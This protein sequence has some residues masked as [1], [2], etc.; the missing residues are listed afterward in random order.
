MRDRRKKLP[1]GI[2]NFETIIKEDYYYVDKTGLIADLIE[3][4]G[5]VTLFTRPRRF[6]KSLNMSMLSHFFSPNTDKSIFEGLSIAHD[7]E[8]CVKYMGQYPVI[9]LSLKSICAADYDTA[10]RM[11]A[12]LVREAALDVYRQVKDCDELLPAER[13]ELDALMQPSLDVDALYGSLYTLSGILHRSYNRK[14][15]ILIDEY[16]VPLAKAWDLGYYDSMVLLI[17]NL[18]ERSLKTNDHLQLA[19]LTGCMQISKESIFTGLNNLKVLGTADARSDESFGFTDQEVRELLTYYDL[20]DR[21][22]E[23]REWYDGYRFGNVNV[24]CPWDVINFCDQLRCDPEAE[25]ENY[26]I[27]SSGN[28]IIRTLIEYSEN[29]STMD[30]IEV[31]VNGGTIEKVIRQD[32]TYPELY[33]SNDNIWSVLYT[34]GYL[35]QK[36]RRSGNHFQL[37]IPNLE[38]RSI[39][40]E[41]ILTLFR[42][43][44]YQD[45][46]SMSKLWEML[47]TGNVSGIEASL[48]EY[49]S[50]TISIR[51]TAVRKALKENFYHGLLVGILSARD[52]WAVRSNSESGDGYSDIQVRDISARMAMVIEVKYA[53]DGDMETVC[54]RAL[55]QI[56]EMHYTENLRED[57]F[58]RIL[59]YG[60]AFYKKRCRVMVGE[61]N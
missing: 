6:G 33:A 18:F 48:N 13:R 31:L 9:S 23:A 12:S 3:S 54:L 28:S 36:G 29:A 24:Y 15:V 35:T 16:D 60:I 1:I 42:E 5:L 38:V 40:A 8:L 34:T 46:G 57:G 49:L 61:E 10:Y 20:S 55:N 7:T 22:E 52:R 26:W 59:K 25:P 14:V 17:R 2:E 43:N 56:D 45:K 47:E 27:N 19:V 30:D 41:Q 11:A 51:D 37:G 39:Y 58:D 44:V 4:G 53:D 50:R 32:L 21:Y